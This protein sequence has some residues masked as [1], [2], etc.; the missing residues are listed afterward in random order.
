MVDNKDNFFPDKEDLI[1]SLQE[2]EFTPE[3]I[4][5]IIIKAEKENKFEA[6]TDDKGKEKEG[7]E[8]KEKEDKT[9]DEEAAEKAGD[10]EEMQKAIDKI[11]SLKNEIDKSMT[12]FLNMFGNIP[13]VITPT[14]FTKKGLEDEFNKSEKDFFEKAFGDKFNVI[15]KGL[16]DQNKINQE[17]LKSLQN[18]HETVNAIAQ[19]PNPYK[20]V[21][22]NYRNNLL[23]KGEKSENG[24]KIIS[25][26]NKPLVEG[27]LEKA[28]NTVDNEQDKQIIRDTL[29]D[30]SIANKLRPEGFNIVKKALDID[31]E[32]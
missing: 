15:E 32:K 13:G 2:L 22:G 21:M 25:L 7:E 3:E 29:S 6:E 9:V 12:N 14:D 26:S 19:A 30:Y 23:E 5:N 1:K 11:V 28:I 10:K 20:S 18:I 27:I 4:D 31:F 8:G 24:K 16:E 17:F